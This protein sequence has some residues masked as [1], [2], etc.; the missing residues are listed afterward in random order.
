MLGSE[1]RNFQLSYYSPLST[2]KSQHPIKSFFSTYGHEKQVVCYHAHKVFLLPCILK[3]IQLL[4]MQNITE[5]TRK[6]TSKAQ[7]GE[8][9]Q[10]QATYKWLN[11]HDSWCENRQWHNTHNSLSI[12]LKFQQTRRQQ[13]I[14]CN[15]CCHTQYVNYCAC[16]WI[17]LILC[18]CWATW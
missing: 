11:R 3:A 7:E 17:Y 12:I 13:Q 14:L 9:D 2:T 1:Q 4:A 8:Q 15:K 16:Y 18:K 10:K 6:Q 5:S